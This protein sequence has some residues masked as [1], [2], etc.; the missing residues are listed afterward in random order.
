[1]MYRNQV[2][3]SELI[4]P[5]F[6]PLINDRIH[7]HKILTSGRAGTKSSF[8]AIDVIY[9]IVADEKIAI[10]V[11]RKHHNKL[12]KTVYKESIRA[13][14]RLKLNKKLFKITVSPMQITY[15][16]NGNTIYFTGSDSIDDTKGMI[17]EERPIKIVVL[18]ELTE[19]FDSGEG[20]DE[21]SNITATFVRGNDDFFEMYYLFN[22]PKNPKALINQ[23]MNKMK[24][25]SDCIHVHCDYRDVPIEWLGQALINEASEMAK[26]DYKMYRWVWLG[27]SVGLDDLIYYMYDNQRHM[28]QE[29]ADFSFFIVGVDYGQMNATTFQVFGLDMKNKRLQGIKEFYHSGRTSGK[30]KSPSDYAKEMKKLLED[31]MKE[32]GNK[33]IYIYIDPSAKGLAE[34]IKR[35]CP[36]AK[37]RDA[38]NDVALG[39]SRVQKLLIFN[40]LVFSPNQKELE[41]ELYLYEYDE[42]AIEKGLERPL[43]E[44]DHC[45]DAMRYAVMGSWRHLKKMLPFLDDGKDGD[46]DE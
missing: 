28:T 11:M 39:I 35:L 4:I 26:A 42:K 12:R 44:N 6:R 1:M 20:E 17:D 5:K 38:K 33:A 43:K 21:I 31:V 8:N 3:L 22:P 15:L 24:Q 13:I 32:H 36:F 23:W 29:K 27:E 18:D 30:Q 10:V 41:N 16:K 34:E 7:M 19:F 45:M 40:R 25:R 46:K 37:V 9:R 2:R 14:N